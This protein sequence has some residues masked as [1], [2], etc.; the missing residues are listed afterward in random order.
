MT[1]D[2]RKL[3]EALGCFATGVTVVTARSLD[4]E[5]LGITANSFNSVSLT[6]PLVLFSLD[7]RAYSLRKFEECGRFA[8]N[9]LGEDQRE[10]SSTFA[11]PLA[12]KFA[13]VAYSFGR[14]GSPV[15]DDA[16]AI[17]DC[18]VRF[19][20]DGGDHVIFVGEVV[21]LIVNRTGRPLLF[22]RGKYRVIDGDEE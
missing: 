12:D 13:T 16:I 4:G 14:T 19:R 11:T 6:P 20:Y 8:V 22:F 10:V 18:S 2:P 21:D 15:L 17:F 5:L 7:R 3:R 1:V 9:I